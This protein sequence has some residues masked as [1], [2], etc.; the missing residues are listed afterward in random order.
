MIGLSYKEFF[1][2]HFLHCFLFLLNFLVSVVRSFCLDLFLPGFYKFLISFISPIFHSFWNSTFSIFIPFYLFLHS[3]FS[4]FYFFQTYPISNILPFFLCHLFDSLSFFRIHFSFLL[5]LKFIHFSLSIL[6]TLFFCLFHFP[7]Q[8]LILYVFLSFI[9]CMLHPSSFLIYTYLLL[10][11][12]HISF[13]SC[14]FLSL[15]FIYVLKYFFHWIFQSFFL[16]SSF[17]NIPNPF[18]IFFLIFNQNYFPLSL[19]PYKC[20]S[21]YQSFSLVHSWISKHNILFFSLIAST[22]KSVLID[23]EQLQSKVPW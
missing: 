6:I 4:W 2:S 13:F 7:C 12:K 5:F 17:I 9:P 15:S 3:L 14:I 11:E 21:R 20:L 10:H 16:I 22:S 8:N 1:C 23:T 18:C 19:S